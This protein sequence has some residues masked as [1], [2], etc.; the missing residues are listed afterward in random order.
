MIVIPVG[1]LLVAG[2]GL[3]W[4]AHRAY[5]RINTWGRNMNEVDAI[6]RVAEEGL[7][8]ENRDSRHIGVIRFNETSSESARHDALH[9]R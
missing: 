8:E 2:A 1:L 6:F 5:V 9:V 7:E 4:Y 3:G